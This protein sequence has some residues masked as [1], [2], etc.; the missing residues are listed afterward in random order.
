[1]R[2]SNNQ[3][4]PNTVEIIKTE[5]TANMYNCHSHMM[6]EAIEII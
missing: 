6:R 2:D 1:M 3:V 5:F 4:L